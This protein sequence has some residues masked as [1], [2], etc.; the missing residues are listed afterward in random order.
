MVQRIGFASAA[1]T[2]YSW[3]KTALDDLGDARRFAA[4]VRLQHPV[5]DA[6]GPVPKEVGVETEL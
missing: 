6:A 5:Q 2:N 4:V 3:T 1:C